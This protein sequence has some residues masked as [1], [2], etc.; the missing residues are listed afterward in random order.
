MLEEQQWWS[1]KCLQSS[2]SNHCCNLR[3]INPQKQLQGGGSLWGS[4]HLLSA[5]LV[6]IRHLIVRSEK[7]PN[8]LWIQRKSHFGCPFGERVKISFNSKMK[9]FLWKSH[10]FFTSQRTPPPPE[11][12][13]DQVG[14]TLILL[15]STAFRNVTHIWRGGGLHKCTKFY[16]GVAVHFL[17]GCKGD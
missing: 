15:F 17:S 7:E 5:P 11:V 3:V 4:G 1:Y 12:C 13:N 14:E 6:V 16:K 8:W 9:K 2:V 10:A